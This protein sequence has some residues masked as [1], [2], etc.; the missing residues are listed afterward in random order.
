MRWPSARHSVLLFLGAAYR[1]TA[2]SLVTARLI[3][4]NKQGGCFSD[5]LCL[6]GWIERIMTRGFPSARNDCA[7]VC[8]SLKS[9]PHRVVVRSCS[10][11][12]KPAKGFLLYP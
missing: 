5:S 3:L 6:S 8:S 7:V 10:S 9:A 4:C 11:G 2:H 12:K 1:T